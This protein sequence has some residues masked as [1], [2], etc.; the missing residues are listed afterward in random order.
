MD[1]PNEAAPEGGTDGGMEAG[2]EGGDASDGATGTPIFAITPVTVSYGTVG[3]SETTVAYTFTV[4]NSGTAG[5]TPT[6]TK[7]GSNPGDFTA[8]GCGSAVL[9]TTSCT[10][11]VTITP[12]TQS[13]GSV[14]GGSAG[15]EFAFTVTNNDAVNAVTLGTA[16]VDGQD[17]TMFVIDADG[18]T[19]Q[20]SGTLGPSG[21]CTIFVHFAPPAVGGTGFRYGSL[22]ISGTATDGGS[23]PG[24]ASASVTGTGT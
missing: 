12:P 14:A 8:T 10:L 22:S 6:I 2:P 5:G 17:A 16:A 4:T 9:P 3:T 11:S 13:L 24:T 21:T 20:C 19:S 18:G 15:S 7:G 23:A 1:A